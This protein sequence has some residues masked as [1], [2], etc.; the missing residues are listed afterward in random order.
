MIVGAPIMLLLS[1]FVYRIWIGDMV[2]IDIN[3]SFWVMSYNIVVMFSSIFVNILNGAGI[4]KVQTISSLI[5]PTVFLGV[6]YL[7]YIMGMGVPSILIAGISA[8]FNGFLLAPIQ[9]VKLLRN[10]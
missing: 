10:K 9:C 8:N 5:S 1:Q 3:L 4:L 2:Q 6:A 7:L